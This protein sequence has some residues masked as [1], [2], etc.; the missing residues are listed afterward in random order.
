MKAPLRL[1][2][3]TSSVVAI[4]LQKLS[5]KYTNAQGVKLSGSLECEFQHF[6]YIRKEYFLRE[7]REFPHRRDK[8][9]LITKGNAYIPC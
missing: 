3:S 7:A 1:S 9:A 4:E 5:N 6:V 2:L 8:A